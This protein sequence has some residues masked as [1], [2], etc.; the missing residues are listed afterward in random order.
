MNLTF[1]KSLNVKY[2][3]MKSLNSIKYSYSSVIKDL[4]SV[5]F[6]DQLLDSLLIKA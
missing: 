4:I 5:N 3:A 6:V 2:G 1:D